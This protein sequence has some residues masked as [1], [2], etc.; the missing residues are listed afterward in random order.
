MSDDNGRRRG[1][2]WMMNE[3][4]PNPLM[5]MVISLATMGMLYVLCF[6]AIPDSSREFIASI[7]TLGAREMYGWYYRWRAEQKKESSA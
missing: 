5:R 7:I 4:G 3:D 1:M 6:H 2:A